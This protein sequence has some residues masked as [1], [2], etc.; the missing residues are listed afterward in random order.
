MTYATPIAGETHDIVIEIG[1]SDRMGF[2]LSPTS[3]PI[4]QRLN[5]AVRTV[6]FG[7]DPGVAKGLDQNWTIDSFHHGIDRFEYQAE[8]KRAYE[9]SGVDISREGIV[10]LASQWAST[11]ASAGNAT[12]PL[13]VDFYN[14]AGSF[15]YICV[16][17]G[18]KL[19][20]YDDALGT[21]ADEGT[22]AANVVHMFVHNDL[23]FVALAGDNTLWIWN[24][25]KGAGGWSQPV[26]APAAGLAA[27]WFFRYRD[28][29][30]A[31]AHTV[32]AAPADEIYLGT[33]DGITWAKIT[34]GD[35]G[36]PKSAINCA[37]VGEDVILV[38]K[39]E[40][41]NFH[42]MTSER[43]LWPDVPRSA[44]NFIGGVMFKGFSYTN[45]LDTIR[46]VTVVSG[47]NF[48]DVTPNMDGDDKKLLYG[49]GIPIAFFHGPHSLFVAFK[50]GQGA[51]V[52]E[53]YAE[54]LKYNDIGWHQIYKSAANK[55]MYAAGYSRQKGWLLLN[56]GGATI[57]KRIIDL[58][59]SEY[60]DFGTA[61]PG[62]VITPWYDGGL[63][64]TIKAFRR[65]LIKAENCTAARYITAYY[66]LDD[67]GS[68]TKVQDVKDDGPHNLT[69]GGITGSVAGYKIRM[70]IELTTDA[71][72]ETPRVRLP[73]SVV[74][75][76][77]PESYKGHEYNVLLGAG[78]ALREGYGQETLTFDDQWNFLQ[79]LEST[80]D[81][82]VLTDS[83]A[84]RWRPKNTNMGIVWDTLRLDEK[85][86][87]VATLKFADM[88]AA[89]WPQ[90]I[91]REGYTIAVNVVIRDATDWEFVDTWDL[92]GFC[93][94]HS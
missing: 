20:I 86:Y 72:G 92:G 32:G 88:V 53:N 15:H 33:D 7:D 93:L 27:K 64:D 12:C 81:D 90:Y 39:P 79:V 35:I 60:P 16:G 2:M 78:V 59:E 45:M 75:F 18:T 52:T 58:G 22:F 36:D 56:V 49:H 89:M 94:Y 24:G 61:T 6:R 70:K 43:N 87:H 68:W 5:P 76:P 51:G 82:V 40:G 26:A 50:Q 74:F 84:R 10:T 85:E 65:V 31:V 67:S 83:W 17:V 42:D 4:S 62:Y 69:I 77:T 63:P 91:A 8:D 41:L 34:E 3:R 37:W 14:S 1:A 47:A 19:R 13:I 71:G 48:T 29:L 54:L 66:E 44:V 25:T 9:S 57:R 80:V 21:W 23:L 73:L 38:G 46:K 30:Y 55:T 28:E 11:D